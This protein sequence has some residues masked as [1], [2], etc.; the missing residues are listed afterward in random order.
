MLTRVY[1]AKDW[2]SGVEL[3]NSLLGKL[4]SLQMHHIFPKA[5]LYKHGYSVP[6][7]NS[8]ANFTFLT[9]ETNLL[10]SDRDPAEYLGVYAA[11]HPGVIESHWIPMDRELWKVD[12]YRE[13]LVARREL[14]AKASNDFLDS[15]VAGTVPEALVTTPVLERT[16]V[17]T[18]RPSVIEEEEY[19][20]LECAEWVATQGL[21]DGEIMYELTDLGTGEPLA[22]FD[23]AWPN[24][25]QEGLSQPVALLLNEEEDVEQMANQ[26][27]Y[28]YFTDVES[29]REYVLREI[30]AVYEPHAAD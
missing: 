12:N 23:L 28:R 11:K 3:S 18:P 21:P 1:R 20:I 22:V 17:M 25:L 29:F 14:L 26:A 16:A 2:D 30:L 5:L 13:F 19:L 8:L 27:G 6:E 10:V 7:V 15:L 24:G 9:Q 4:S